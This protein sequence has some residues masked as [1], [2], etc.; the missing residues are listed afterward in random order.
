MATNSGIPVI[1][2]RRPAA[3]EGEQVTEIPA[4]LDWIGGVLGRLDGRGGP[5][6]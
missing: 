6:S 5:E 1:L 3:P 4:A 2:L